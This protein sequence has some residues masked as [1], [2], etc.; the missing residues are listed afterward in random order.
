MFTVSTDSTY[1]ARPLVVDTKDVFISLLLLKFFLFN[2]LQ[3]KVWHTQFFDFSM[4]QEINTP[5]TTR[6]YLENPWEKKPQQNITIVPCSNYSQIYN[7]KYK[8]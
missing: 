6:L 3:I 4:G 8:N 7:A 1:S 5:L 2:L